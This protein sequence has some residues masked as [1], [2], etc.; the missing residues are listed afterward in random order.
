M[1]IQNQ[2]FFGTILPGS[3]FVEFPCTT[4][5]AYLNFYIKTR[6]N[7]RDSLIVAV[8]LT[9]NDDVP[10]ATGGGFNVVSRNNYTQVYVPLTSVGTGNPTKANIVFS[11]F[12]KDSQVKID[13]V[14]F[15]SNPQGVALSNLN[16][17]AGKLLSPATLTLNV[18]PQPAALESTIKIEA[19]T[20]FNG[21]LELMNILGSVA[22]SFGNFAVLPGK[23]EKRIDLS[24][25]KSGLYLLRYSTP[26]GYVVSKLQIK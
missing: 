13:N 6:Q 7:V 10:K 26:D 12:G 15:S 24:G 22:K 19:K 16:S 2:T 11:T 5:P 25:L 3:V 14:S 1:F 18:Y 20:A 9:D 21:Q 23:N 4:R 8:S 17:I